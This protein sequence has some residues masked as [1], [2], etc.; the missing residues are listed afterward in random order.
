MLIISKGLEISHVTST[1]EKNISRD[2]SKGIDTAGIFLLVSLRPELLQLKH[3][4]E[5]VEWSSL[6]KSRN[7]KIKIQDLPEGE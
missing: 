7:M 2:I 6:Q 1:K 4:L 3:T 5:E